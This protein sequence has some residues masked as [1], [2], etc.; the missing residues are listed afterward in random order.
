M[1][2]LILF[3]AGIAS[4]AG[5]AYAQ[6]GDGINTVKT[7]TPSGTSFSD[8]QWNTAANW[9]PSGV[10]DC[11][12]D[13]RIWN[14]IAYVT[15][16]VTVRDIRVF[17]Q[18]T[19]TAGTGKLRIEG[20]FSVSCRNLVLDEAD[21]ESSTTAQSSI[22]ADSVSLV[23]NAQMTIR[24]LTVKRRIAQGNSKVNMMEY[25]IADL[26][27]VVLNDYATF[28]APS[29]WQMNNNTRVD[30]RGDF[31]IA[32][33]AKYTHNNGLLRF[34]DTGRN[35]IN[36]SGTTGKIRE[37]WNIEFNKKLDGAGDITEPGRLRTPFAS[38][39]RWIALNKLHLKEAC[40][41]LWS[42]SEY[43]EVRDSL[44]I[45]PTMSNNAPNR[46]FGFNGQP[47]AQ[48][49][50]YILMTGTKNGNIVSNGSMQ[51]MYHIKIN[52]NTSSLKVIVTGNRQE[53]GS[54]THYVDVTQGILEFD[55]RRNCRI[56]ANTVPTGLIVRSG[57]RLVAPDNDS[58]FFNGCWSFNNTNSF[59]AQLSTVVLD[60]KG[61]KSSFTHTQDTI[62]L[63]NLIL[64]TSGATPGTPAALTWNSTQD[65]MYVRGSLTT[66][67]TAGAYM[68]NV[69][70]FIE[71][72][73]NAKQTQANSGSRFPE[74][75]LFVG[76]NNQT[77]TLSTAA[78]AAYGNTVTFNKPSGSVTLNSPM[79]VRDVTFTSGLVNT[80]ATN[81]LF[82]NR[83]D[84]I[85]GG[86]TSSYVNGPVRVLNG[87][88]STL[89]NAGANT[90][91]NVPV[92]AGGNYR[93]IAFSNAGNDEFEITYTASN[94]KSTDAL[95]SPIDEITST[96]L[97]RIDHVSGSSNYKVKLFLTGKPGAWDNT[98]VR[99]A[100]QADG[101]APWY[102]Q[103]GT[104]YSSDNMIWSTNV[105][106]TK[107]Y[108]LFT[109]GRDVPAPMMLVKEGVSGREV[110]TVKAAA[111]EVAP[112]NT[113]QPV[114]FNVYPNPVQD[115]LSFQIQ[116]ADKG[117]VTLSDMSGKMLGMY[118]SAE[119]KTIDMS[120]LTPGMYLVSFTDGLNKITHRVVKNQ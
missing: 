109:H 105:D 29:G 5:G 9:S 115:V 22:T 112:A 59:N 103:G 13:V 84:F 94:A 51:G 68:G 31:F 77:V 64:R 16:N 50:M 87:G 41:E 93:P 104:Y 37:F 12:D 15:S 71:G 19:P 11:D 58:L 35:M 79:E 111:S 55:G 52:K 46:G 7:F 96:D 23:K 8:R 33:L 106:I 2:K 40:L 110:A 45:D 1:K 76:S 99:I 47:G 85:R 54:N 44:V 98:E 28:I 107:G 81:K 67:D 53:I 70:L 38:T 32:E 25:G 48:G 82:I 60:G 117:V 78:R 102:N 18:K 86:N 88:S 17:R 3:F 108:M 24:F 14:G 73:L 66:D 42:T 57:G 89:W 91:G 20:N 30:V 56:N 61:N 10:P 36:T 69:Q 95:S 101:S 80:T 90:T 21:V 26:K 4:M 27:H 113:A 100:A 34:I 83:P 92:G 75:V 116:Q 65:R 49:G 39:E 118:N 63:N 62:Y 72:N 120:K 6:C 43:I 74:R 119:V 97:W 114:K